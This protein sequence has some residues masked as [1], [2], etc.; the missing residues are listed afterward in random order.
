M[1]AHVCGCDIPPW[2]VSKSGHFDTPK[3]VILGPCFGGV[4]ADLNGFDATSGKNTLQ[5]WL[6]HLWVCTHGGIW[7]VTGCTCMYVHVCM[8]A[9]TCTCTCMHMYSVQYAC[10]GAYD[11]WYVTCDMCTGVLAC[12][13]AG[14]YAYACAGA[15]LLI[16]PSIYR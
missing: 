6:H 10:T 4:L 3:V 13:R 5:K 14:V 12:G 8:Y 11:M 2:E 16:V 7:H 1:L 9:C 15:R